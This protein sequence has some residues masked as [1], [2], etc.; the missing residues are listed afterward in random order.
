MP[1]SI[2]N[3]A[4]LPPR[5]RD[6]VCEQCH[7]S[8]EARIPNPGKQLS[9]FRPDQNLEEVYSVYVSGVSPDP[10]RPK[11]L[12]V[13]SQAQQLALSTCA[14]QSHGNL[15]CGTCHDP[16]EQP[17]D[18]QQYF[19][20]RCLSCHGTALLT[21][22]PRPNADCVA[23]HMPRR[24]ATDGAHTVFTDH[25]IARRPPAEPGTPGNDRPSA[26]VAW[27]AP[28]AAL[29][30]RNLGL[31][32]VEVGERS[33][34]FQ[35]VFQGHQRLVACLPEFPNDPA[36]LTS[37]GQVLLG[38]G[39]GIDAATVFERVIRIEPDVASNYLHEGLAW[40]TAHNNQK[41]I[42][43]LEK[44]LERDPLLEQPYR[45]LAK[46]YSEAGNNAMVRVTMDRY[47]RAF[48]KSLEAKTAAVGETGPS[49]FH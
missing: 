41:A 16:H 28:P 12:K 1:G 14:R 6:S 17:A 39:R 33:K 46:T 49:S 37:I 21:S 45:E 38:A 19:R 20:S 35:M 3:P 11:A 48:P 40:K 23:C 42:K 8:G 29:Q 18:P 44:A 10:L 32:E 24:P 22:H 30:Q 15:W 27:Y 34:S 4:R 43:Y 25:R 13:I 2:V 36:V 9:D 31:A 26:L 5:A 7:L 47:R